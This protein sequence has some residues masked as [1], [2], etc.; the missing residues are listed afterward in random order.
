MRWEVEKLLS[1]VEGW[2][3]MA[4]EKI[5]A[6]LVDGKPPTGPMAE[7][8]RYNQAEAGSYT[9]IASRLREILNS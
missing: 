2:K 8:F 4:M 7:P 3:R 5:R 9:V 1:E 6:A